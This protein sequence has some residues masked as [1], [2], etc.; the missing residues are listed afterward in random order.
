MLT[1]WHA[2][3]ACAFVVLMLGNGCE[4]LIGLED[5]EL[6]AADAS[7]DEGDGGA[8]DGGDVDASGGDSGEPAGLCEEYC[9]TAMSVCTGNYAV[10]PSLEVCLAVC[11][12]LPPG[13]DGDLEGNTVHC[14]YRAA[15]QV[16]A[17]CGLPGGGPRWRRALW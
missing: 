16:T 1:R 2:G 6:V 11:E 3:V 8:L 15:R 14:R 13:E 7:V 9:A 17:T 12:H 5:R 4:S 10:Y